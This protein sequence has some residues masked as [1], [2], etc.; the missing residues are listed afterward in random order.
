MLVAPAGKHTAL[1]LCARDSGNR[2]HRCHSERVELPTIFGL[3]ILD[4]GSSCKKLKIRLA[5]RADKRCDS[6]CDTTVNKIG[7][8][9]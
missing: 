6:S 3:P 7:R 8:F 9:E 2:D 4:R 5:G 1:V